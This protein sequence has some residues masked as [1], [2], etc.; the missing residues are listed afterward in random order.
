L[1]D[2]HRIKAADG[3]GVGRLFDSKDGLLPWLSRHDERAAHA[4]MIRFAARSPYPCMLA[5]AG[6]T[7]AFCERLPCFWRQRDSGMSSSTAIY[8]VATSFFRTKW[9]RRTE[10]ND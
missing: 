3:E 10:V 5:A 1:I 7:H 8:V 9:I 6:L 2:N 4:C